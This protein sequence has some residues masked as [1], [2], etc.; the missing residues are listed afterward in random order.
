MRRG[1]EL[2]DQRQE[3]AARL[4][5]HLKI[6]LNKAIKKYT[7]PDPDKPGALDFKHILPCKFYDASI[8]GC[9]IYSARP[10]SCRI[11]PFLGVYG[12]EDQEEKLIEFLSNPDGWD[13]FNHRRQVE[14]HLAKDQFLAL[15]DNSAESSDSRLWEPRSPQYYVSRDLLI[16]RAFASR[17]WEMEPGDEL[18]VEDL[19]AVA[20]V[21]RLAPVERHIDQRQGAAGQAVQNM[22]VM[23]GLDEGTGLG[24]AL[25]KRLVELHGGMIRAESEF[26]RGSRFIF[27]IPAARG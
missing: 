18:E 20:E 24:L 10:W 21:R 8:R 12:S 15:G 13:V 9:K 3:D 2:V 4:A 7:L 14:F 25:T 27:A 11:F 17:G 5:K 26:G 23:L 22:N 1:L 19:P 16:G 6:P